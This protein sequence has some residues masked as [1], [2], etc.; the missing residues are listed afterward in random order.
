MFSHA[1]PDSAVCLLSDSTNRGIQMPRIDQYPIPK[2]GYWV[3]GSENWVVPNTQYPT[4]LNTQ[5]P[6]PKVGYPVA[7]TQYP[8]PNFGYLPVSTQYPIPN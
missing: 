3:L 8:I 2:V 4:G 6:I 7:S 5:Y 1:V